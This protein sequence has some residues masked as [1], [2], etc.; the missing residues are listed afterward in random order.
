VR[1]TNDTEYRAFQLPRFELPELLAGSQLRPKERELLNQ[2]L[3][4]LEGRV[5]YLKHHGRTAEVDSASAYLA[6][7]RRKLGAL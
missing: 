2:Y 5:S 1:L 7:I 6:D 4:M 3:F